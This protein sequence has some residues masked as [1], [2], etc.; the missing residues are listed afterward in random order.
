M[1]IDQDTLVSYALGQ[2]TPQEEA[3]VAT[4]LE[5]HPEDAAQV[6]SYLESLTDF[7]LALE[8]L[9][10]PK[11]G[12]ADLLARI[13]GEAPASRTSDT[14]TADINAG[15]TTAASGDRAETLEASEPPPVLVAPARP[16]RTAWWLGTLAAAA[17]VAGLYFTVLAPIDPDTRT[18]RELQEYQAEPGSV[19]YAL[20]QEGQ[21]EP[22]GTLVRLQDGRVFVALDT[23][24]VADRVYQA[25]NIG[26]AAVSLGTFAE[27]SFVSQAEV[28][29]GN[30]FGL[31]LEP[32]G[33]S[34]QPT[35]TPLTL[36]E[37]S[38]VQ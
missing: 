8:P 26:D 6:S 15:T 31:S 27:R 37:L 19:S 13:H 14:D 21:A 32:P 38:R 18:A 5:A 23:P 17:V 36:I 12:E 11:T 28:P 29:V 4:Y 1:N 25:W 35:T 30:T 9:P 7:A 33:G 16:R 20:T 22:L 3:G 10:L 24:P 34:E 2:L